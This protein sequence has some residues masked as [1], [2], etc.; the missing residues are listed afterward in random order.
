M[1]D[2][3]SPDN[4][5]ELLRDFALKETRAVV[6][7]QANQGVSAARNAGLKV[8]TGKYVEFIDSDDLINSKTC[9]S[10]FN[11]AEFYNSDIIR[12]KK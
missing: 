6:I 4:C 5:L 3:G 11:E 7:D 8:A 12:F 9:E 2:D 1:V 10:L